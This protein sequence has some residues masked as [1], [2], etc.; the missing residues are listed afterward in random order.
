[1]SY[2]L[3][4]AHMTDFYFI[5]MQNYFT[6]LDPA[7]FLFESSPPDM[8]LDASDAK[9]VDVIHTNA[10]SIFVGGL[11]AVDPMGHVDFYPNGGSTQ[12]GCK[13]LIVGGL[14]DLLLPGMLLASCNEIN[15]T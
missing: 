10:D 11:G 3:S 14:T 7:G 2:N 9:F 4:A 1:M 15:A 8:R 13:H 12:K 5:L 6:G